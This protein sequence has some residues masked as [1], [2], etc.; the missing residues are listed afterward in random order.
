MAAIQQWMPVE[1]ALVLGLV[2]WPGLARLTRSEFLRLREYEFVDS[3][4]V[5]GRHRPSDHVQAHPAER[6]GRRH[7]QRDP[8]DVGLGRARGGAELPRIRHHARR[9]SRSGLLISQNQAAFNTRPWL[10]WWPGLFIIILALSVNFIGDGLRDAFDPRTKRIPSQRAMDR[11]AA[12]AN[13]DAQA[14][15]TS[16]NGTGDAL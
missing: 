14:R 15:L 16:T 12:R 7:R 13:A 11:A 2:L 3:A 8:A 10:F 4:R 5:A 9:T 6:H 1:L